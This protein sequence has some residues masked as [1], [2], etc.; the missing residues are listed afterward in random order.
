MWFKMENP[1]RVTDKLRSIKAEVHSP[2]RFA[3]STDRRV[4]MF[5]LNYAGGKISYGI[6]EIGA[7]PLRIDSFVT[8]PWIAVDE[9]SKKRL[10]LNSQDVF[11]PPTPEIVRIRRG[12]AVGRLWRPTNVEITVPGILNISI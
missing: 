1:L 8:H 3:N 12:N 10:W 6:I 7:S 5:W 2:V 11:Y 9:E 4:N